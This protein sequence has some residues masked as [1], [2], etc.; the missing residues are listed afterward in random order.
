MLPHSKMVLGCTYMWNL[1]DLWWVFWDSLIFYTEHSYQ[2]YHGSIDRVKHLSLKTDS[3]SF[4]NG[5]GQ[6]SSWGDVIFDVKYVDF[7]CVWWERKEKNRRVT[8]ISVYN[9]G[10]SGKG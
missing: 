5:C 4:Q 1:P 2:Y 6:F 7:R 9:H 10:G 3:G 8:F